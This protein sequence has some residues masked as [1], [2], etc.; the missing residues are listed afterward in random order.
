MKLIGILIKEG[1]KED[2][3]KK[4]SDK[5][6]VE[7]LDFVLNNP[8][9][10]RFNHKYTDFV[11]KT[12]QPHEDI[13]FWVDFSTNL[14]KDFDKYQSQLPK[15]DI[16]QYRALY[17]LENALEPF[18][19][20]EKEK[21]L[22]KQ[23]R[24]IF[25]DDK[26]LVIVPETHK[27]SC[28]YGSNT[29][30]C[31]TA[32]SDTHFKQYTSGNKALYYIINKANSTNKDYSKVAIHFTQNGDKNFWD[33]KDFP[34]EKRE[35]DV[36]NYAF[37]EL[38]NAIDNDY[39]KNKNSKVEEKY[40]T[41]FNIRGTNERET[42][43]LFKT[44][45][46]L[47]VGVD[48]FE[49]IDG[50]GFGHAVGSLSVTLNDELIDLYEILLMFSPQD[51]EIV[52]IDLGFSAN[53]LP[54]E[55]NHIDLNLEGWGLKFKQRIIG[56]LETTAQLLRQY[57]A[58]ESY[59]HIL[60]NRDL[61]KKVVGSKVVFTPTYGYTFGKNKGLVKK[62]VDYLDAGKVGTK[63]D[64]LIDIGYLQKETQDGKTKFRKT[65]GRHLYKPRDLRGQH[66]SFFA[67]AKNA[68]ILDYTKVGNQFLLKKGPNFEAFK[69]GELKAL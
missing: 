54:D 51:E 31:T 47:V 59:Y 28:K 50:M 6:D 29:K 65:K 22:E 20:K 40:E 45:T 53:D 32:Q 1:R 42:S 11:L 60:K 56:S 66:A 14:V 33:S 58:M 8:D 46:K 18:L 62:L 37:P 2:L 41:L 3:K 30:W 55:E 27:A 7:V 19:E 9:L 35:V 57:I 69:S 26:F 39:V 25:E 5:F 34:M 36:F 10:Q 15:K 24:K 67:A 43:N 49:T 23:V 12:L 4:Y 38:I 68:G 63:L 52:N 64:F 61:Q 16:N 21:E 13:A 17:E 44:K 48:G